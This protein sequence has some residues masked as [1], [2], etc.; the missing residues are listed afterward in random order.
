M[1]KKSGFSTGNVSFD[2]YSEWTGR[3]L[4]NR[5]FR[6]VELEI[7][8]W[9]LGFVWAAKKHEQT[10][11]LYLICYVGSVFPLFWI[12]IG[13]RVDGVNKNIKLQIKS[14]TDLTEHLMVLTFDSTHS[15]FT[16]NEHTNCTM[17]ALINSISFTFYMKPKTTVIREFLL[18][19]FSYILSTKLIFFK[20]FF[21]LFLWLH[22]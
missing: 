16:P 14:V 10:S 18:L 4:L 12:K 22:L 21:L 15:A 2:D 11:V 1:L 13:G 7:N 3:V 19:N 8:N 6:R 17:I 5:H 9:K 20:H